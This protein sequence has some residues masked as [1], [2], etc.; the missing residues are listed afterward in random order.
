MYRYSNTVTEILKR[1]HFTCSEENVSQKLYMEHMYISSKEENSEEK[2][3]F[4]SDI[5]HIFSK[6]TNMIVNVKTAKIM[7]QI[8]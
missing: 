4:C 5:T 3:R 8:R 6:N 1:R 7:C 2:N